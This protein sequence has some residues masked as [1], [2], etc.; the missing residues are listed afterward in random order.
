MH[1]IATKLAKE[2]HEKQLSILPAESDLFAAFNE[3]S[4]SSTKVV[5]IGERPLIGGNGKCFDMPVSNGMPPSLRN[6]INDIRNDTGRD[7]LALSNANSYLRHL[8]KQGVLLLNYALTRYQENEISHRKYWASFTIELIKE[9]QQLKNITFVVTSSN[10]DIEKYISK[11]N[12]LINYY[13][14]QPSNAIFAKLAGKY[15]IIF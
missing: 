8:P 5:I 11:Y 4:P 1:S 13:P 2:A 14:G 6:I 9:M 3:C 7:S 10:I 12:H 15:N